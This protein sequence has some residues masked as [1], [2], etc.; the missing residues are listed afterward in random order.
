MDIH[1]II[2]YECQI[3]DVAGNDEVT[4]HRKFGNEQYVGCGNVCRCWTMDL[5]TYAIEFAWF[6][7]LQNCRA[8]W[9]TLK[10]ERAKVP[11]RVLKRPT[12]VVNNQY[13]F[14]RRCGQGQW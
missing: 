9:G 4:V 13:A 7:P 10:T 1:A 2:V 11:R 5:I 8:L 14:H 12:P 6:S 3:E